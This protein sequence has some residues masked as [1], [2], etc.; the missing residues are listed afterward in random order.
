[1]KLSL[2]QEGMKNLCASRVSDADKPLESVRAQLV[3]DLRPVLSQARDS[4]RDEFLAGGTSASL[5]R[6]LSRL[7][8]TLIAGL[9]DTARALYKADSIQKM[10]VFATGGY[11]RRELFPFSDID[12]SMLY[13]D[14]HRDIAEKISGFV[15]YSLWDLGFTV[16][17]TLRT[18][19]ESLALAEED[20]TICTALLD[21]HYLAGNKILFKDFETA[22]WELIDRSSALAFVERKLNERDERHKKVGDSRYVLEPNVKEGKGGLRDLQTLY[23]LARYIYRIESV[24]DL[25]T[26]KLLTK[27]ELSAFKRAERF[28][29]DVRC[30]LHYLAERGEERL[31]FDM[32]R[33]ISEKMGYTDDNLSRAVERFMKRYFQMVK[34]VGNLTRTICAVLEDNKK[35]KPKGSLLE[36]P[37]SLGAFI[38]EGD[39]LNVA[40]DTLFVEDP[41][42]LIALF[43]IAHQ[44][45]LDIHPQAWQLVTRN[46]DQVDT[47]LIK[48]KHANQLFMDILLSKINP[49]QTLIR[50]N[51]SG[52]L[53]KFLPDFGHTIGQM[54]FDMYHV[55]TV[56]EHTINAIRILHNISTGTHASELPLATQIFPLIKMRRALFLAMLCHDIAK[57]RGGDHSML[58]EEIVRKMAKRFDCTADEIETAAWLVRYHLLMSHTAFKRD[59][60]DPKTIAD[61]VAQVQSPERLRLLLVLTVSDIRAVGPTIWNGWKGALL[62]D[63]YYRAESLMGASDINSEK[64][65]IDELKQEMKTALPGWSE[66]SITEY[67]ELGNTGF[68]SGLDGE[69]HARIARMVK[70]LPTLSFPLKM[71]T[72]V[73]RFR[74]ITDIMLC[75]PDQHGLFSQISGAMALCDV[76]IMGAK[77]F[78]LKNGVAVEIFQVQDLEGKAFDKPDRLAR[79]SVVIEQTLT[80]QIR[81]EK[82]FAKNAKP[83]PSRYDAFK[84][85]PRVFIENK[86][87]THHT[88]IE[89]GGKDRI[90]FLYSVTKVLSDLGLTISTAHISTYGERAVDVFY[91][92]DVFGMKIYHE[93]KVQEIREKLITA[94]TPA[95]SEKIKKAG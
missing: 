45:K 86:V 63:L 71:D 2:L 5:V 66:E 91:V 19:E 83:Y 72:R 94:L 92:K 25:V 44:H 62:R 42:Q 9:L 68:W 3:N 6:H 65:R 46:L 32:Q 31:T 70:E 36:K 64:R 7:Q 8:D 67:L 29:W 56:D 49:D 39:R 24:D 82:E 78:T 95:P 12:I 75:T 50:M 74:A 79:L 93:G 54:Q 4:C 21:A 47:R 80:G 35:R 30:H 18:V 51:E 17:H 34:I 20:I 43:H 85:P 41:V 77:I 61:F 16:G 38:V 11:G 13:E 90:G 69:S 15:V 88:V 81:L 89:V 84:V 87:S 55:F 1:M 22:F 14:T 40:T 27:E 76:N 52:L 59:I 58:G 26:L 28:L 48:D 53:G 60:N 73:D 10:C 23:W 37:R 33:S 57:G